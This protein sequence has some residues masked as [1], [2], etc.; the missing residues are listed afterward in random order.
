MSPGCCFCVKGWMVRVCSSVERG[1]GHPGDQILRSDGWLTGSR[2]GKPETAGC[3]PLGN[4][5]HGAGGFLE[6]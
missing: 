5:A 1:V 6:K 4:T 3:H 2:Q